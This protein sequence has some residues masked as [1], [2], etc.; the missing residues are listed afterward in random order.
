MRWLDPSGP[1]C[2]PLTAPS[3][4]N[5]ECS[6]DGQKHLCCPLMGPEMRTV[7]E[8]HPGSV[9]PQAWDRLESREDMV[10]TC[11][12]HANGSQGDG[13]QKTLSFG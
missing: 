11:H 13:T 4:H 3:T 1:L 7:G 5:D 8:G 10:Q 2:A 9:T 12:G 6:S